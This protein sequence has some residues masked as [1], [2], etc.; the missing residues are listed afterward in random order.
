[1]RMANFVDTRAKIIPS[2]RIAELLLPGGWSVLIA[3]FD[4]L[5]VGQTR[6]LQRIAARGKRILVILG[7]NP[8]AFLPVEA[9]A[10]LAAALRHVSAVTVMDTALARQML[11]SFK[12]IEIF[13]EE[14]LEHQRSAAF[15]K[16]I[17]SRQSSAEVAS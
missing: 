8:D 5:T 17:V 6:E 7:S 12:T 16:F 3:S 15:A 9:R 1:M 2:E 4:P 11:A 13:D 14:A 10:L